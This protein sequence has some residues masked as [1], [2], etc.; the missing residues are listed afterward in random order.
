MLVIHASVAIQN[1][2]CPHLSGRLI[3]RRASC[4]HCSQKH[5]QKWHRIHLSCRVV[6]A[7]P[8]H[9]P[10]G[11]RPR[12]PSRDGGQIPPGPVLIGVPFGY[13]GDTNGNGYKERKECHDGKTSISISLRQATV[14]CL[15]G[16]GP[17][18]RG[19]CYIGE[20]RC[21]DPDLVYRCAASDLFSP[22]L[23]DAK[24]VGLVLQP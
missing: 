19:R 21:G 5:D 6:V 15:R 14:W 9:T 7:L 4:Q 13:L 12:P 2:V 18:S 23:A 8:F 3:C 10:N 22:G 17:F 16:S 1:S 20:D 11:V 24:G